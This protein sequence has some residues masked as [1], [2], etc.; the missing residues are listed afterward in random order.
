MESP[1]SWDL[2][3]ASLAVTDLKQP[4]RVWAF[5]VGQRIVQDSAEHQRAFAEMLQDEEAK[6]PITGPSIA[7]RVASRLKRAGIALPAGRAPDPWGKIATERF[8]A[9]SEGTDP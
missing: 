3:T 5:L 1:E 6:G 2:L 7:A 9:S 8:E 4:N